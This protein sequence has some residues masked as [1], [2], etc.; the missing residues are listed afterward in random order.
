MQ[1]K[2]YANSACRPGLIDDCNNADPASA[3]TFVCGLCHERVFIC[4]HCDRG[5]IYCVG[6]CAQTARRVAQREAGRRYQRT[7]DGR[8]AH[9]ERSRRYRDR[10]KIVTH[11]GS[12]PS[13]SNGLVASDRTVAASGPYLS[14]CVQEAFRCHW[15]GRLCS[16]FVRQGTLRHRR[17]V[18][19]RHSRH[20]RRGPDRRDHLPRP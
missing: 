5:Q 8:F 2:Y 14:A 10:Q 13:A 1:G 7:R 17:R 11:Q 4:T 6:G 3:R 19:R 16:A 20:D 15:C 18:P 12:P 9:A